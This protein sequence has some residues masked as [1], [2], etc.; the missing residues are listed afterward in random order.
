MDGLVDELDVIRKRGFAM[1]DQEVREGM[2]CVAAPVFE[3]SNTV[4]IAAVAISLPSSEFKVKTRRSN[5]V[6]FITQLANELSRRLGGLRRL[7]N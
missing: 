3:M 4:A 7:A 2:C 5:A 1:D 6:D